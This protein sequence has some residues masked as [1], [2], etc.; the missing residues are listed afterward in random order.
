MLKRTTGQQEDVLSTQK[1]NDLR[2]TPLDIRRKRLT[3]RSGN[4]ATSASKIY[5]HR[6]SCTRQLLVGELA[7]LHQRLYERFQLAKER[8][9]Y[10]LVR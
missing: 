4:H 8:L 7:I 5:Q 1:V 9:I 3:D 10:S 6:N 2:Q